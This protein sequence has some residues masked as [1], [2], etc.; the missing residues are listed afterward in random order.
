ML[1]HHAFV[2]GLAHGKPRPWLQR[3]ISYIS[4]RHRKGRSLTMPAYQIAFFLI[5]FT[6][7][8]LVSV[9]IAKS[10]RIFED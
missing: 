5:Q 8:V 2:Y 9:W 1:G 4:R 7:I 6:L 10:N 3:L